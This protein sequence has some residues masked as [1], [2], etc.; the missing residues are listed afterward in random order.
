MVGVVGLRIGWAMTYFEYHLI[1]NLPV[2][3]LLLWWNRR[4]LTRVHFFW[5]GI[6][7]LIAFMATTPWDNWA[8][9]QGIWSF[10]WERTTPVEIAAFGENWRL[11]LEEYAFFVLETIVVCLCVIAFLPHAKRRSKLKH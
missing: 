3:V 11:P 1:F 6:L 5:M 9:A 4:R 8:V 2:I 10:D 7:S